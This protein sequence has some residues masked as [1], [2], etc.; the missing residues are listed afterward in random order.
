M[1]IILFSLVPF[2]FINNASAKFNPSK[3]KTNYNLSKI[4][5]FDTG[6]GSINDLVVLGNY[7]YTT[8]SQSGLLTLNISTLN[9]LTLV[10]VFDEDRIISLEQLWNSGV[11]RM[12]GLFV[13]SDITYLAD[14]VNGL[15]IVNVSDPSNPRKVG[16]YQDDLSI[17]NIFINENLAFTFGS[18]KITIL[19]VSDILIPKFL[20]SINIDLFSSEMI[21]DFA[22]FN[23]FLFLACSTELLIF[24]ITNPKEP[25][26]MS[27]ITNFQ[28]T[29][30]VVFNDLLFC[31]T[32]QQNLFDITYSLQI[33]DLTNS[34]KPNLTGGCF[35]EK[36]GTF[37]QSVVVSSSHL[38]V[39]TYEKIYAIN[40]TNI[41]SPYIE[42]SIIIPGLAL[43]EKKLALQSESLL[44][45][46]GL[47][48]CADTINGLLVYNFSN[49][50]SP[51]LITKFDFGQQA[52]TL[53]EENDLIYLCTSK[54]FFSQTN[55]EII[56]I[57]D[58][59]QPFLVGSYRCNGQ[60]TDI[61][62]DEYIAY[63][64]I[65]SSP[66]NNSL[67]VIDVSNPSNPTL[68]GVYSTS[69]HMDFL[70]LT[71]DKINN[72]L[73]TGNGENSFSIL[74]ITNPLKP[75]EIVRQITGFNTIDLEI[76]EDL[77]F[78]VDWNQ[79]G[80]YAI[81]NVSNP[82]FPILL[83]SKSLN[84][85]IYD[86]YYDS[87]YLY[88]T[89]DYS[90]LVIYDLENIQ[91]PIRLD[92]FSNGLINYP[93]KVTINGTKAYIAR[94]ANGLIILEISDTANIKE[95]I[96]FRPEYSG[97]SKDVMILNDL[98]LLCDGWDGLEILKLISPVISKSTF[99][100]VTIIPPLIGLGIL[101]TIILLIKR[102][103]V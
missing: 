11:P 57:T 50:V 68:V 53:A 96:Q 62:V 19:D 70:Q 33:Y 93:C 7:L 64:S 31:L 22:V 97:L 4:G 26:K 1:I 98:I 5:N 6:Y 102:R 43:S 30:I 2:S 25:V 86:L 15:V 16:S 99:L 77:L 92:S 51:Y 38:Y 67:E 14:G 54:E 27:Q 85:F 80:G 100:S 82:Y 78:V 12:E 36:S 61:I 83:S 103:A 90:P 34:F 81:Y 91:S 88:L 41:A 13:C 59:S 94:D 72:L 76:E 60:I 73:F 23:N 56:S 52:I 58:P 48:F 101:I 63:I 35:I 84:A 8:S 71:I 49:P 55:L 18:M 65:S 42:G 40:I 69:L 79:F 29:K 46:N 37:I 39:A 21:R 17:N 89:T 24:D 44:D 95:I 87:R 28:S 75:V 74:N 45:H 9:N 47:V 10:S 66:S 3:T 20:S 32:Y